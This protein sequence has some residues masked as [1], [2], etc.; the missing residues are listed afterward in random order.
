[1]RAPALWGIA[2]VVALLGDALYRLT[3]QAIGLFEQ[4]LD[5]IEISVLVVWLAFN[6]YSEGYRAFHRNFSP[7][8]VARARA[9]DAAP[10]P[11]FVILAPLYCMGLVHATRRRLVVSWCITVGIVGIV[12]LVR[13]L[14]QPW[15]G[16][17][18][19]GV[20]VGLAWGVASI[21]YYVIRAFRGH[22]MPVAPDLPVR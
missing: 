20:V 5:A 2:G 9:L 1:M 17:V 11:L 22:A 7:R 13:Q 15:R 14:A 6:A 12:I 4:S 8:V 3:P 10:R 21:V 16:I 19:A 18:D